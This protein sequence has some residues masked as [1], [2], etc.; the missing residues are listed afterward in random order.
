MFRRNDI[1]TG[2]SFIIYRY[3]SYK[4]HS[5]KIFNPRIQDFGFNCNSCIQSDYSF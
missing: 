2:L 1:L 4:L 3:N 5:H